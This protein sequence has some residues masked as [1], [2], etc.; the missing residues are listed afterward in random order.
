M[1]KLVTF[2]ITDLKEPDYRIK[3]T[4]ENRYQQLVRSI[5]DNGLIQPIIVNQN[6]NRKN[7]VINGWEIVSACKELR[8]TKID[9]YMVSL[10]FE[11]EKRAHFDLNNQITCFSEHQIQELLNKS[12]DD[13]FPACY[14]RKDD[15]IENELSNINN[16]IRRKT[17]NCQISETG[18][19]KLAELRSFWR[20]ETNRETINK[21]I[22]E[23]FRNY[24][25]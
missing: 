1:Q 8:I 25:S 17:F 15:P 21:V 12:Y 10:D 13:Y 22:D 18:W 5:R 4:I 14:V 2:S 16:P 3:E 11:T 20:C 6:Q 24:I 23:C 9:G 7:I 19:N